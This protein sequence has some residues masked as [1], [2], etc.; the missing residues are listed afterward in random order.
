MPLA[1][2]LGGRVPLI[3]LSASVATAHS[4]SLPAKL[5]FNWFKGSEAVAAIHRKHVQGVYQCQGK[6]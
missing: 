5:F 1:L 2:V 6:P 3:F 4:L